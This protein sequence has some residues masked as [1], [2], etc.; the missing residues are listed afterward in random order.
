MTW[1]MGIFHGRLQ[2]P[3]VDQVPQECPIDLLHLTL[4]S[5]VSLKLEPL[6]EGVVDTVDLFFCCVGCGK[7]FWEGGHH[8]RVTTQFSYVLERS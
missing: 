4:A 6:P 3:S 5:G 8:K 2:P 1:A 7:V